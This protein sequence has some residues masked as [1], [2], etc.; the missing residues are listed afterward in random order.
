MLTTVKHAVPTRPT[1]WADGVGGTGKNLLECVIEKAWKCCLL[2]HVTSASADCRKVRNSGDDRYFRYFRY[3][4]HFGNFR[5][6]RRL[7]AFMLRYCHIALLRSCV[8]I[9][10]AFFSASSSSLK[11]CAAHYLGILS[12]LRMPTTTTII[13]V[14]SVI[15][16]SK[17][18]WLTFSRL[19]ISPPCLES[20]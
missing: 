10:K 17:L 11:S 12:E 8:I 4:C 5:A 6:S 1:S 14:S 16:E 18:E 20:W 7:T 19:C 13:S 3:I 2:I 9:G 15:F